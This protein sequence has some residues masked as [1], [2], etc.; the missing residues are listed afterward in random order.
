V[1]ERCR[2]YVTRPIP[3][4]ARERL[5]EACL[6]VELNAGERGLTREELLR[7]LAGHEGVLTFLTDKIDAE[8]IARADGLRVIA[9]CAVGFDNIDVRAAT[10]HGIIVTNTPEVLTDAAADL[11]WALLMA[12]ARR[13][14]EADRFVREGRFHGWEPGLMLGAEWVGKTL[15]VIGVGRIGAAFA[16]RS[17]GFRMRVLYVNP[18]RREDLERELGARRVDL[19]TALREADFVSLHVPLT[20]ETRHLVNAERLAMMKPTAYLVNTSRGPVVDEAALVEALRARRIAGAA[21]DVYE[22]EPQLAP[23]LAELE[24]VVL[25]PHI[26]S[27]TVETR[28]RMIMLAA[29][30]VFAA[31]RGET[32][33]NIVNPEVLGRRR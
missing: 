10:E 9:N 33:P 32:P 21:L 17:K 3:E 25:A 1:A 13:V 24:N 20:P 19:E 14:V 23:G 30:N 12:A 27:A 5:C 28:T 8:I 26:G 4:A 15:A 31:M 11:A 18:H 2:I 29:E 6:N 16:L 7:N 22:H